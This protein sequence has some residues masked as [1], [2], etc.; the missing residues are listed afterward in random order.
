MA[1]GMLP[2][3]ASI[4]SWLVLNHPTQRLL[5][6]VNHSQIALATVMAALLVSCAGDVKRP[7]IAT[8]VII[9]V[10]WPGGRDEDRQD[11]H[12]EATIRPTLSHSFCSHIVTHFVW[13]EHNPTHDRVRVP[14]LAE[15]RIGLPARLLRLQSAPVGVEHVALNRSPA[16]RAMGV[17]WPRTVRGS[18]IKT[19]WVTIGSNSARPPCP[20]VSE[21]RA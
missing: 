20:R 12:Q 6:T 7:A 15:R 11:W 16:V 3:N 4:T 5:D 10:S 1:D 19:C 18:A 14:H 17:E 13:L 2:P 9:T 8:V 21:F